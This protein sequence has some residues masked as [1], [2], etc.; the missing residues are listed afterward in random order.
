MD[1]LEPPMLDLGDE[2][3]GVSAAP[4]PAAGADRDRHR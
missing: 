3:S 2:Q 1:D 4:K